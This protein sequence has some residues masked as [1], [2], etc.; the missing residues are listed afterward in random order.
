MNNLHKDSRYLLPVIITIGK[1]LREGYTLFYGRVRYNDLLK[2]VY[3][4]KYLHGR[5]V[6][7]LFESCFR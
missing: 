7:G 2:R 4:L 3:V 6:V 5:I 1:N